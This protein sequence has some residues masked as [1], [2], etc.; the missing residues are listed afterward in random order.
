MLKLEPTHP[1]LEPVADTRNI[2]TS[3]LCRGARPGAQSCRL[4]PDRRGRDGWHRRM[5]AD[6]LPVNSIADQLGD[7][8]VHADR[9]IRQQ[10]PDRSVVIPFEKRTPECSFNVHV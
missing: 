8:R 1:T 5:A 4:L 6:G 10:G 3:V 7:A 2:K 9:F